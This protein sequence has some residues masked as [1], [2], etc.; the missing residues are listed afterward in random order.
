MDHKHTDRKEPNTLNQSFEKNL[1]LLLNENNKKYQISVGR[2]KY[3]DDQ[4]KRLN[5]N[6]VIEVDRVTCS[7]SGN[8]ELAVTFAEQKNDEK[9]SYSP[10]INM[11][12]K[13]GEECENSDYL[14]TTFSSIVFVPLDFNLPTLLLLNKNLNMFNKCERE[15]NGTLYILYSPLSSKFIKSNGQKSTSKFSLFNL[16]VAFVGIGVGA[17]IY[18]FY[19]K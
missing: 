12:K 10:I 8:L 14:E 17:L 4:L 18:L 19:K 3:H 1:E 7:F 11:L 16:A 15:G 6:K 9:K 5:P 13:I 2:G